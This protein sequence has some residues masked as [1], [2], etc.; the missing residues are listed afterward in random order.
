MTQQDFREIPEAVLPLTTDGRVYHLRLRPQEVANNILLV[1]D[2]QRVPIVSQ[3]FD[4]IE[5]KYCHREFVTHTGWYQGHRLTVLSTGMSTANVEIALNE[6]D[7]LCN[8]DLNTRRV[9]A[10]KTS[11]RMLRIGTCGALQ[12]DTEV[13]SCVVSRFAA[14]FDG[15]MHFYPR[16]L[17]PSEQQLSDYLAQTLSP[18]LQAMS[19]VSQ[20]ASCFECLSD[21][22]EGGVTLTCPGFYA[23]QNR[24]LRVPILN[25]SIFSAVKDWSWSS[26]RVLNFEMETAMLLALGRVLGHECGSISLAVYNRITQASCDVSARMPEMIENVLR[27]LFPVKA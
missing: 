25:D 11:L 5:L 26:E 4:Q 12:E 21:L 22:G 3:F 18:Q 7:A 13:G 20:A 23:A 10:E 27:V 17:E 24:Q 15:Q 9:K 2:P 6:L 16:Q 14:G 19:Y 1:G 8:I